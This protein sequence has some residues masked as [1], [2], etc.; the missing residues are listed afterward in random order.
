VQLRARI[1]R[2]VTAGTLRVADA[3]AGDLHAEVELS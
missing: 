1:A 3:D 2:D